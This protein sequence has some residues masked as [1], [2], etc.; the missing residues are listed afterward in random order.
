MTSSL[1]QMFFSESSAAEMTHRVNASSDD[2]DG[3]RKKLICQFCGLESERD[4]GNKYR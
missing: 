1:L 4:K 3:P 2:G